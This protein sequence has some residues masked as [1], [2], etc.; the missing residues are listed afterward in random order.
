MTRYSQ[1]SSV[2]TQVIGSFEQI[3]LHPQLGVLPLELAQP[4]PLVAGQAVGPARSMRS[5]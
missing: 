5:C 3:A 4:G 1:P 2:G